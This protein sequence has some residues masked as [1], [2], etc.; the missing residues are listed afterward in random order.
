MNINELVRKNRTYRRFYQDYPLDRSILRE[1]VDLARLSSTGGN[2]QSLKYFLSSEPEQNA[3]IFTTLGWAGYLKDWD[4]PEEGER[5]GGYIV[6]LFDQNIAKIPYWDHGIAAQSIL[7]GAA[8]KGLGGCQFGNVR[9]DELRKLLGIAEHLEILLVIALGR[10]KEEVRLVS[11]A[12]DGSIKYYRDEA[13]I[14]YVPKRS[15]DDIIIG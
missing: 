5:P 13:G 15:L 10:P 4:G 8:E 14:H 7:L 3:Q 6:V 9:K 2:L 12:P 11:L 1:L